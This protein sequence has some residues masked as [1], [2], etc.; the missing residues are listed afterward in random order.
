MTKFSFQA[1]STAGVIEVEID[2][3]NSDD[4]RPQLAVVH[5]AEVSNLP[6]EWGPGAYVL[7]DLLP[8][9]DN[10]RKVYVGQATIGGLSKRIRAHIP[11]SE[12]LENWILAV[13]VYG[14]VGKGVKPKLPFEHVQA[15][16]YK[17]LKE[18][19]KH[20]D[21]EVCNLQTPGEIALLEADR[22]ILNSYIKTV[23]DLLKVMGC[24]VHNRPSNHWIPTG[25]APARQESAPVPPS[26]DVI[27]DIPATIQDDKKPAEKNLEWLVDKGILP[28]GTVLFSNSDKYPAEAVISREGL[29]IIGFGERD[30]LGNFKNKDNLYNHYRGLAPSG[31]AK[32][33]G[34]PNVNGWNFWKRKSDR[35][36]LTNI[37]N[38]AVQDNRD[39]QNTNLLKNPSGKPSADLLTL[40]ER[41]IIKAGDK[42][43]AQKSKYAVATVLSDGYIKVEEAKD[44]DGSNVPKERL[45]GLERVSMNLACTETGKLRDQK[46]GGNAWEYWHYK[47][48]DG[49]LVE[50]R[51]LK[52]RYLR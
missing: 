28:S 18:F 40:I 32:M 44:K 15:L 6:E 46:G 41:K 49:K 45:R 29:N 9:E 19:E 13:V 39:E 12:N 5:R 24:D 31:A 47:N 10:K 20:S 38:S 43:F 22:K 16:E 1:I 2:A 7:V 26:P 48:N 11:K 51:E 27:E 8:S 37:W 25:K 30:Y 34:N 35:Q 17:L 52:D 3:G 23:L 50:L 4:P 36:S 42:L 21:I 14:Q 33:I